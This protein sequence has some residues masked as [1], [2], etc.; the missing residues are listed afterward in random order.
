MRT[1][2]GGLFGPVRCVPGWPSLAAADPAPDNATR[3]EARERF[4]RGLH[5]FENG[6]NG[7]A[8]AEFNRAYAL[9]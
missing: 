9:T 8:L 3:A 2:G 6:D 1:P 5:L 4:S 7:G